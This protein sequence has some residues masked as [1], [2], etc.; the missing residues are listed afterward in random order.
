MLISFVFPLTFVVLWASAFATGSVAT[1]DATPFA[2]LAFRFSI[3]AIGFF[4]VAWILSEFS[5]VDRRDLKHSVITG[6]LFH[7]LYLGGCWY[8]FSVG[9]PAGVSALI[10]CTQPILTA[11]FAGLLLGEH[12]SFKNWIGLSLGFVGAA[13]VLGVDF[14]E[15]FV[16]AGLVA[17]VIALASITTATIWQRKFS[18]TLPLATNN[19]I[20]AA[21]A[22]VFHGVVMWFLED[23][24]IDL[25]L[26]FGLAMGWQIIAV[27]FGAFTILMYLINHNSASQTSALFFL[28]PPVAAVMGWVLLDESLSMIDIIG[29]TVA[30]TGVYLATRKTKEIQATD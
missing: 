6:L 28:V 20:Q 24:S 5:K 10:V 9:I 26:T 3:V 17:N 23:P 27:S 2:A 14:G 21:S 29:F 22:A 30:S 15:E 7:G 13:L 1:Q 12:V 18:Q 25:T 11:I 4:L 19:A 8:S 16:V